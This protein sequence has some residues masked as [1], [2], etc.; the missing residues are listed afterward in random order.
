MYGPESVL[1]QSEDVFYQLHRSW[2]I[3]SVSYNI[4]SCREVEQK[5]ETN[6]F[7]VKLGEQNMSGIEKLQFDHVQIFYILYLGLNKCFV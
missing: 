7:H 1:R 4:I 6:L 3:P 2:D 5:E